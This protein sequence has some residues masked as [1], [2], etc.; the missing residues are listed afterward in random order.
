MA[1]QNK[2]R[3]DE[4]MEA[5]LSRLSVGDLET[6]KAHYE[7]LVRD[8]APESGKS[9]KMPH[10]VPHWQR[11]LDMVNVLLEEKKPKEQQLRMF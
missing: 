11:G 3:A 2:P 1:N 9:N 5:Y 4:T 8:N 7:T 6:W 10:M